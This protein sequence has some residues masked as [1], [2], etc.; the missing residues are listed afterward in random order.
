MSE[1]NT[2]RGGSLGLVVTL[3]GGL[4]VFVSGSVPRSK[5]VI[6]RSC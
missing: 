2:L 3:T 1:I 6:T 5:D 4:S